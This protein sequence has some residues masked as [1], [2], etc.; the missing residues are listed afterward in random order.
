MA[1]VFVPKAYISLLFLLFFCLTIT[2][3][4]LCKITL[5]NVFWYLGAPHPPLS[6]TFFGLA[7]P[8]LQIK[9]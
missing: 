4:L 8:D 2:S 5:Q 9:H 1:D 6:L 3:S 7:T